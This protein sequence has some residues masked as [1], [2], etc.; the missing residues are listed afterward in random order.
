MNKTKK[1]K[2]LRKNRHSKRSKH[3]NKNKKTRKIQR[4]GGPKPP[5]RVPPPLPTLKNAGVAKQAS[6]DPVL[7]AAE[8]EKAARQKSEDNQVP[9]VDF[10]LILD[11]VEAWGKEKLI[12]GTTTAMDEDIEQKKRMVLIDVSTKT[13]ENTGKQIEYF[14]AE[15]E[16]LLAELESLDNEIAGYESKLQLNEQLSQQEMDKLTELK[17]EKEEKE[18][19]INYNNE[20]VVQRQVILGDNR[21]E[22]LGP[23]LYNQ[24]M[25]TGTMV[26]GQEIS[27]QHTHRMAHTT[28]PPIKP[29]IQGTPASP[30]APA[31][32]PAAPAASPASPAAPAASPAA[33]AA[34]SAAT[35]AAEKAQPSRQ[36]LTDKIKN[37]ATAT[38]RLFNMDKSPEYQAEKAAAAQAKAKREAQAKA[39]RAEQIKK[40]EAAG[41]TRGKGLPGRTS[42]IIKNT[43]SSVK[44]TLNP[45]NKTP[46]KTD[47][48]NTSESEPLLGDSSRS[49]D[50][51]DSAT[52]KK[53][54][55]ESASAR[56]K[57]AKNALIST[58]D[59]LLNRITRKNRGTQNPEGSAI[60]MKEIKADSNQ[61]T[62]SANS[63]QT[64]PTRAPPPP[65]SA[66]QESPRAPP[67]PPPRPS[68]VTTEAS[69]G[70]L[71]PSPLPSSAEA[72]RPSPPP[73]PP[74]LKPPPP[75]PRPTS[76]PPPAETF[77]Q[78]GG[79]ITRKNRQYIH[80][81]KNN[82]THLFNKEMEII[83]SI[84]NFKHVHGR[85][86]HGKN[87]PEN[88]QK[89]FIKVIK[90]S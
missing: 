25:G 56:L 54:W 20:N 2:Y 24:T 65:P 7:E 18:K 21:T 26:P 4:G 14:N 22:D 8:L 77:P 19:K 69:Q 71:L 36:G 62:S 30:A 74:R 88:I 38:R 67:P 85:N 87:K 78:G 41:L 6:K 10:P 23:S 61:P 13:N 40:E 68:S 50:S 28:P 73:P 17:T 42:D 59:A 15:N 47:P 39:H 66:P 48:E 75:P 1:Y 5:A 60:E 32:S 80:E 34:A 82:R 57:T 37:A 49:N 81:I 89:K 11:R 9:S 90:R 45:F 31:A 84:R 64:P 55:R 86:E 72:T 51:N 83:N 16:R 35:S 43:L 63:S 52:Q 76:V 29:S 44:N 70:E 53:S 33:P 46:K 58:K 27:S 12:P 79:N 3:G